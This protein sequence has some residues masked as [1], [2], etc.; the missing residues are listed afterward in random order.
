M[1]EN[2]LINAFATL[3]ITVGVVA[4]LLYFVKKYSGKFTS[5]SFSQKSI[6]IES[7][8]ALSSKSFLFIINI[9]GRRFVIGANDNSISKISELDSNF[10]NSTQTNKVKEEELPKELQEDISFSNFLKQ[11][12]LKQKKN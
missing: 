7:K 12:L 9:E 11:S 8:Q 3:I 2:P 6:K 4:V 5:T 10:G 1:F